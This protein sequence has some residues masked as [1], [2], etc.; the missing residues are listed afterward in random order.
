MRPLA[1]LMADPSPQNAEEAFWITGYVVGHHM[2]SVAIRRALFDSPVVSFHPRPA[3]TPQHIRHFLTLCD[4]PT[5]K[6]LLPFWA[7]LWDQDPTIEMPGWAPPPDSV[8]PWEKA[9]ALFWSG[10]GFV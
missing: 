10:Y 2:S 5:A 7:L 8:T 3:L 6:R 1:D 4:T 9:C